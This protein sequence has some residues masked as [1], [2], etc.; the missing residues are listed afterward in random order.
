ML[1]ENK[2]IKLAPTGPEDTFR[3][4]YDPFLAHRFVL[5]YFSN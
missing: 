5:S 1:L 2:P 4:P 3:L